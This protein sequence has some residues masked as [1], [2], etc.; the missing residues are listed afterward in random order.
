MTRDNRFAQWLLE[1]RE[2]AGVTQ[3]ELGLRTGLSQSTI[4]TLERGGRDPKWSTVCKIA[5]A[6]GLQPNDVPP[7][8]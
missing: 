2:Q 4:F 8:T 5:R 6:L 7:T 1:R 3:L